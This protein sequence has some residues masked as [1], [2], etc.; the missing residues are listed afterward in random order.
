MGGVA[1]GLIYEFIFNPRRHTN[2]SKDSIDGGMYSVFVFCLKQFQ[3]VSSC[4]RVFSRLFSH[5]HLPTPDSGA[6]VSLVEV[7]PG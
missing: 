1:A 5:E 2:Q 3:N 4:A 6:G 7:K